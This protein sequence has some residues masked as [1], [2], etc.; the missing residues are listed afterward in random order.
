MSSPGMTPV[1]QNTARLVVGFPL[2]SR[3]DDEDEPRLHFYLQSQ[4]F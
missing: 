4:P 2:N 3:E 1:V